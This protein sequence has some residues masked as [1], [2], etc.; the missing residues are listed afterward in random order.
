M[1]EIVR[2]KFTQHQEMAAKLLATGDRILVERSQWGIPSG[3]WI[4]AR[5]IVQTI[6]ARF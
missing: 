6:L 5:E 3:V 2:A 1:E 4:C